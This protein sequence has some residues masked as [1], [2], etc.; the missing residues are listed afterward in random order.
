MHVGDMCQVRQM[1]HV[2]RMSLVRGHG[3][4]GKQAA[5]LKRFDR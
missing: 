5:M 3:G 1:S 4:C 2:G